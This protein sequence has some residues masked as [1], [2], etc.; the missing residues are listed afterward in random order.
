MRALLTT[1][2][3]LLPPGR[4][5]NRLLNAVGHDVHPKARVGMCLVRN[6]DK[7]ELAEGV[8][9]G[10]FNI[11]RGLALVRMG[12]GSLIHQLNWITGYS[13]H[14]VGAEDNGYLRQL[15]MATNSHIVSRH[16]IDCG[17]G[18]LMED[19]SWI[20]GV[21]TTVMTHSFDP[22]NGG[23]MLLPVRMESGSILATCCTVLPG[24]VIGTDTLVAA[25]STIWSKQILNE[26]SLYGGA[27]ARRLGPLELAAVLKQRNRYVG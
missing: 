13:G 2:I 3:F 15:H 21:R 7:F 22:V 17:G 5:K 9:I 16:V 18:L 19:D 11:F 23:V 26:K 8:G 25:G 27:P 12:R 24:S 10:H 1:L 6:V 14:E 4:L 20:T